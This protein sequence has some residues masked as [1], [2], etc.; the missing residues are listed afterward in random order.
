MAVKKG[1]YAK[2]NIQT[3]TDAT[4]GDP[5]YTEV[6]KL[7]EWSVS[8]SSEKID[9]SAAG[10][11]WENHE[12]GRL[13]WEGEATCVDVDTFWFAKLTEK[14][15]IEFYDAATDVNPKFKGTA[16]LDVERTTPHDDL[17]ETSISFTGSG[18][19]TNNV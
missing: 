5:I 16:S 10:D 18:A 2:V 12:I 6:L 14:V 7:R 17:I 13:S 4:T 1:Q 9:S 3:S 19:L 15:S 11:D 8:I